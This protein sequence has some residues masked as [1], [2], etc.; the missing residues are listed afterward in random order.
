M[1]GRESDGSRDAEGVSELLKKHY[2]GIDALR[3]FAMFLV[4]LCHYVGTV[5]KSKI[6]FWGWTGVDVF[7]VLSG[8]LITG[9]LFDSLNEQGYFKKFYLRRSVRIFPLYYSFWIVILLL[10]P[11]LRIVWN[12]HF[13][14]D[15]FY[16]ANASTGWP[17]I[18][19]NRPGLPL[20]ELN[21]GHF[22]SLCVEEQFYLVWPLLLFWIKNRARLMTLCV[23]GVFSTVI[24][25]CVVFFHFPV[26]VHDTGLLYNMTFFQCDALLIGAWIALW[27]RGSNMQLGTLKKYTRYIGLA[28]AS[29]IILAEA[30]CLAFNP[31]CLTQPS[32][33]LPWVETFGYTLI[34]IL[35]AC[36]M[37]ACLL[38]ESLA[39]RVL[40]KI[41]LE[42]LGRV[43]YGFY[44]IHHLPLSYFISIAPLLAKHHLQIPATI[45]IFFLCY[46]LALLSFRFIE[47]P[48][49][50]LKD[51]YAKTKADPRPYPVPMG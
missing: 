9:I 38:P 17:N 18:V 33:M 29:A 21:I 44:V 47:S 8:F 36:L 10:T 41:R 48:F 43:S 49:L 25:R 28:A 13:V 4:F 50:K 39:Y 6:M 22:W 34:D 11:V 37:V 5:W 1:R 27:L 42:K 30:H 7:F 2:L 12:K 3:G 31:E 20:H 40:R 16:V 23:V 19:F 46:G 45:A 24:L 32:M 14:L 51:R 26:R 35:A 15:L